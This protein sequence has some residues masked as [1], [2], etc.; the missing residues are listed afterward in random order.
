MYDTLHG[1]VSDFS[2]NGD[3]DGWDIY[4]NL[5]LYGVWDTVLFG[6]SLDR[7]CYIGRGNIFIPIPAEQYHMFKI[8]MKFTLPDDLP[9]QFIPTKGRLMWQTVA[10]PSWDAEK[11]IDFDL[12]VNDQWYTYVVNVGKSQYWQGDINTVRIYPFTDGKPDIRITVKAIN[13]DATD[14]FKC[15]NTQCD[16]H[17]QYSHPCPGAGLRSSITT[18]EPKELYTI[19][20]DVSDELIISIDGYGNEK[21]NLGNFTNLTGHDMAKVLVNKISLV[22]LGQYTYVESTYDESQNKLIILS[23]SATDGAVIT[24]AGTAAK[25][26]GFI[27]E[28]DEDISYHTTGKS[29]AS[30]FDYTASRRLKGFEINALIDSDTEHTAY[31]HNPNQFTVE[32][33][34][35]DISD[36][37][38]SSHSPRSIDIDYYREIDGNNKL[39][40]DGSHPINDSGRLNMIK[41]NGTRCKDDDNDIFSSSRFANSFS[42][43]VLLRPLKSDDIADSFARIINEKVIPDIDPGA[44]RTVDD[45][46]YSIEVDWLVNKGDLIGF[47]NFNVLTP[48]SLNQH[49][50]NAVYF[51][52]DGMPTGKFS[53]GKPVAKGVIGISF[54]ARSNR[55]QENIQLEIDLG[56]RINIEEL[57][58]HGKELKTNYEYNVAA[59]LDVNWEVNL[60]NDTHWHAVGHCYW[61]GY[62]C[63]VEHRNKYYGL[64]CLH[65]CVTT[66]DNGQQGDTYVSNPIGGSYT[67]DGVKSIRNDDPDTYSGLVT[68]GKHAYF[69]VNGDDEWLNG[70]CDPPNPVD[71]DA[72][73]WKME[74]KSPWSAGNAYDYEFDPITFTLFF[75]FGKKVPIHRSGMY[76]KESN[77]FKHLSVSYYLGEFGGVGDAEEMNWKYVEPFNTVTL[78]GIVLYRGQASGNK[79]SDQYEDIYFANPWPWAKPEY[80]D[81]VCVNWDVYQTVMNERMNTLEHTFDEVECHGFR[82]HTRWHKS[83]KIT[84]LEVFSSLYIEPSLLDNVTMTSSVYKDEWFE[85]SFTADEHDDEKI[86]AHVTGSPRYF[87]LEIKSQDIFK[88]KELNAK[89][90]VEHLKSLECTDTIT[91]DLAPQGIV[92]VPKELVIENTYNIPLNLVVDVPTVLFKQEDILSWIKFDSPATTINAE[93]GPGAVVRKNEDYPLYVVEGQVANNCYSYYLKN[94]IDNKTSYIFSNK[95]EW[96]FYRTLYENTDVEYSNVPVSKHF[97]LEFDK[98]SSRYWKFGNYDANSY[99]IN[100]FALFNGLTFVE[101]FDIYIQAKPDAASGKFKTSVDPETGAVL[102]VSVVEDDFSNGTYLDYWNYGFG[103]GNLNS[104]FIEAK[105]ILIPYLDPWGIAYIRKSF[106]PGIV[107]FDLQVNFR[108]DLPN[109]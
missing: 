43:V 58:V 39:I 4:S 76:F 87:K 61:G 35:A 104:D 19:E 26:L 5:C 105:D 13:I 8:T 108:F 88:L 23:G 22:N 49:Q 106:P 59:C 69:Y 32:A 20:L 72:D 64:E 27:N 41:V 94:L 42:K 60:H 81:N 34:R 38:S 77:N 80:V 33:G 99:D 63:H 93:V 107:S 9:E 24:V 90:S 75:P 91:A 25:A 17:T 44:V 14:Y 89:I 70:G 10:D 86:Q 54:Y 3:V 101:S 78:D 71:S 83:T 98:V 50:P 46:T 31:Y 47:Y 67:Y 66:P 74:F 65:D 21:V 96:A 36:S 28:L 18:G 37:M 53:I 12:I 45:V 92:T 73:Y 15:G 52:V 102:P 40:I 6:T 2:R 62:N 48:Y 84:E 82:Y 95:F 55:I 103:P 97:R 100:S 29:P 68:I 51:E 85:L 57:Y 79:R 7:E 1:Y 56:R 30:G 109:T 11:S 16:F